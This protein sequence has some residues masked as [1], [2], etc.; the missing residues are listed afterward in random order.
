M[1]GM[2]VPPMPLGT[3]GNSP[4]STFLA[5]KHYTRLWPIPKL[6]LPVV[7]GN[8]ADQQSS[9]GPLDGD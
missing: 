2:A 3:P 9:T 4:K 1:Q 8:N 5:R 6:T 7:P